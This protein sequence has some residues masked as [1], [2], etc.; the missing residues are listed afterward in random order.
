MRYVYQP[1]WKFESRWALPKKGVSGGYFQERTLRGKIPI[2]ATDLV[3]SLIDL[4]R[5]CDE[6]KKFPVLGRF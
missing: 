4:K 5:G 3:R 1:E 6:R 2:W